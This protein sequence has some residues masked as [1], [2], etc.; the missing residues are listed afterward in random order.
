MLLFCNDMLLRSLYRFRVAHKHRSF[1]VNPEHSNIKTRVSFCLS[2]EKRKDESHRFG[3]ACFFPRVNID[4]GRFCASR[5]GG[6]TEDMHTT[7]FSSSPSQAAFFQHNQGSLNQ[8]IYSLAASGMF[9]SLYRVLL[10][11][12]IALLVHHRFHAGNVA[13]YE[14]HQIGSGCIHKKPYTRDTKLQRKAQVFLRSRR[15][16]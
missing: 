10:H 3:S 2:G 5:K 4:T 7:P 8:P 6:E 12:S 15:R 13:L 11:L 16:C 9:H 14:I 1:Q